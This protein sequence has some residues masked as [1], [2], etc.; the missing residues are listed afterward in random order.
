[1]R[2]KSVHFR[3]LLR[4]MLSSWAEVDVFV[5]L[6]TEDA[7][8]QSGGKFESVYTRVS[9]GSILKIHDLYTRSIHG[10]AYTRVYTVLGS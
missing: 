3:R 8:G 1:M 7:R 6:R 2:Y 10:W 4:V 9:S 5:D